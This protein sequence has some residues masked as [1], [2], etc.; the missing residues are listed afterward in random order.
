MTCALAGA[1]NRPPLDGALAAAEATGDRLVG[2]TFGH[3][4]EHVAL[5]LR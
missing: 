2:L 3:T 1:L 5:A 4:G